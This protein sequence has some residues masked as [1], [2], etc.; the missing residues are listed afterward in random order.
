MTASGWRSRP[1]LREAVGGIAPEVRT[2]PEAV[3]NNHYTTIN[4][5]SG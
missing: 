4:K 2:S 3:I 1:W 5:K